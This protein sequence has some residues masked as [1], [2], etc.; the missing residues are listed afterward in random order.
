MPGI[1]AK[2]KAQL[3]EALAREAAPRPRQGLLLN[4]ARELVGAA[5]GAL[6]GE[7][8][9]DVRRWR[10]SCEQLAVVC[11]APEPDSVLARFAAL[12]QIVALIEQSERRAVGVTVDGV[13]VELVV[14]EPECFGTALLSATGSRAYV[15]A[16]ARRCRP[17]DCRRAAGGP[18]QGSAASRGSSDGT[19]RRSTAMPEAAWSRCS[20]GHARAAQPAAPHRAA[21][22]PDPADGPARAPDPAQAPSR[23]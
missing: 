19:T 18:L 21:R 17:S 12:P 13:P 8:A 3:L 11:A 20:P 5:A 9:G 6:G 10:D 23:S 1:G 7:P 4:R 22:A 14:A 15:A 2:T 16:R